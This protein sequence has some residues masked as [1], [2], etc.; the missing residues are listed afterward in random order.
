MNETDP[1]MQR[2]LVLLHQLSPESLSCDGELSKKQVEKKRRLLM[3]R[4]KK[5]EKQLG[6]PMTANEVWLWLDK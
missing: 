3:A 6:R 5:L 2:F 1:I 4:W